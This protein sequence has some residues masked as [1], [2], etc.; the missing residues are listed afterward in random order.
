MSAALE[1][2]CKTLNLA[3]QGKSERE[4]LAKKIIA[5]AQQG[6]RNAPLL[7]DRMLRDIAY[8]AGGYMLPLVRAARYGRRRLIEAA[9]EKIHYATV[10]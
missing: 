7:R 2:V 1:D 6:E 10:H 9:E 4:F 8:G 3:D 5:L